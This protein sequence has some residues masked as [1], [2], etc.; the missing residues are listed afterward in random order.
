MAKICRVRVNVSA[1]VDPSPAPYG[2]VDED[3]VASPVQAVVTPAPG[4]KADPERYAEIESDRPADDESR[5]RWD[6]NDGWIVIRDYYKSRV[7]RRNGDVR[8][9][10]HHDLRIRSEI[11]VAIRRLALS[12]HR[13]HNRRLLREKRITELVSPRRVGSHHVQY[14]RKR[15]KRLHAGIPRQLIAA[16]CSRESIA[17]QVCGVDRPSPL[18]GESDPS[19]SWPPSPA[20]TAGLG[21]ARCGKRGDPVLAEES[22]VGL[23]EGMA[24][25]AAGT[26]QLEG[27][28]ACCGG[29]GACCGGYW[30]AGG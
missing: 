8:S 18:P 3:R 25:A 19:K 1:A 5:G 16:Y 6:E 10:G 21:T 20:L 23:V 15:Q 26:G 4:S 12:L 29:Y 13:V 30:P 27:Y 17:S 24:P 14:V 9:V 7:Y 2:V 22:K 11:T 28:G